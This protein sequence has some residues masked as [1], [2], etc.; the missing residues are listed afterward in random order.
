MTHEDGCPTGGYTYNG[1]RDE[2]GGIPDGECCFFCNDRE[3]CPLGS[4]DSGWKDPEPPEN[5]RRL[6]TKEDYQRNQQATMM[7]EDFRQFMTDEIDP[8]GK[9]GGRT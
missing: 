1:E 7:N 3:L 6:M 2:D 8:P 9:W 5:G 4:G